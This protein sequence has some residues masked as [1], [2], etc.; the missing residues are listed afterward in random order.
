MPYLD[1]TDGCIE[2][3]SLD[4]F[5]FRVRARHEKS[6]ALYLLEK[7]EECFVPVVRVTR[8]WGKRCAT[9]ELPLF[10]G[11]VFCRSHRFGMLPILTTPGIVGVLRAGKSPIPVSGTEISAIK[12][13]VGACIRIEPCRYIHVGQR[14]EIQRGP[15]K[16]IIGTIADHRKHD[17]LVLSVSLIRCSILLHVD[18]LDVCDYPFAAIGSSSNTNGIGGD[19]PAFVSHQSQKCLVQHQLGSL[20]DDRSVR[21]DLRFGLIHDVSTAPPQSVVHLDSDALRRTS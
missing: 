17:R 20:A 10:S 6:V 12:L 9:V 1:N 16:G 8:K 11:Y 5:A 2:D 4:W 21:D 19:S 15:L 14:V 18:L 13:A 3:C 7:K